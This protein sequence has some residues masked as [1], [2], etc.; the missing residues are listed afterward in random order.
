MHVLGREAPGI[1]ACERQHGG[2]Q[3]AR[4]RA[5]AGTQADVGARAR[6]GVDRR[7]DVVVDPVIRDLETDG[8]PV[9]DAVREAEVEDVELVLEPQVAVAN[10]RAAAHE[11][12]E[13]LERRKDRAVETPSVEPRGDALGIAV[14]VEALG[15]RE[16]EQV[17]EIRG[18][19]PLRQHERIVGVHDGRGKAYGPDQRDAREASRPLHRLS[20]YAL[21]GARL[22]ACSA[23]SSR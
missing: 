10:A 22:A 21:G 12:V 3:R 5:G 18:R 17:F 8:E 19:A 4:A 7:V 16:I 14:G 11:R 15:G 2:G 23:V 9:R 6:P 20:R 1:G 13:R